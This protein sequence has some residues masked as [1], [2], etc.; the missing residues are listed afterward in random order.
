MTQTLAPTT[1]SAKSLQL[2]ISTFEMDS[3]SEKSFQP[4]PLAL[5]EF[6]WQNGIALHLGSIQTKLCQWL[7]G[8]HMDHINIDTRLLLVCASVT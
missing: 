7:E 8:T 3:T 5:L 4:L 2:P 1:Q 6:P